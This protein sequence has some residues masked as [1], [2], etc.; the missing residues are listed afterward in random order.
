MSVFGSAGPAG[1]VPA[2]GR[3][4]PL[5]VKPRTKINRWSDWPEDCVDTIREMVRGWYA[6]GG[7]FKCADCGEFCH[8]HPHGVPHIKETNDIVCDDCLIERARTRG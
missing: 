1:R 7:V 8:P 4:Y 6:T 3:I 5:P 2:F